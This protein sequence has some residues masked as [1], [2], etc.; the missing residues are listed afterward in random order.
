MAAGKQSDEDAL[1]H[2][3]LADDDAL[4]LEEGGFERGA[5]SLRI[6]A[7]SLKAP[8]RLR[9][10][11]AA[12]A[13]TGWPAGGITGRPPTP[14]AG[15]RLRPSDGAVFLRFRNHEGLLPHPSSGA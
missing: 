3:I 12:I 1:K 9:G 11:R 14:H 4:D 2:G 13:G 5:G 10:R 15:R 8:A 7:Q 6:A